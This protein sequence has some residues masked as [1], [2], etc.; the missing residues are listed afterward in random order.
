MLSR[1]LAL[2]LPLAAPAAARAQG[3]SGQPITLVVPYAAGGI[4]DI[5]ARLV[6]ERLS[7]RL[8]VP[9]VADNRSGAGGLI[10]AQ[11]VARAR[12]DG[13]TLLM[14]SSAILFV[15]AS[16][17]DLR[18]D[19]MRE[20]EPVAFVAGLPSVLTVN[21]SVP[22]RTM[23]EL[24]AWLRANPGRANCGNLGE[25][26]ND[27]QGCQAIERAAGSRMEHLTYRGLPP[28]DLDL[29]SGAIQMNIGS[30]PVQL[31]LVRE[32]KLRLLAVA[33]A[34]RLPELPEV[35][36]L[37]ESGVAYDALAGN[38]IFAPAGTPPAVVARLNA[39]IAALL[40]EPAV[41]ERIERLGAILGPPDTE[42]LRA[43]FQRDWDRA[44]AGRAG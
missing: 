38:A 42:S 11:A 33:T 21:P 1:R 43:R 19:P 18:F 7:A 40:A 24:L 41:R 34:E 29:V 13:H 6:A 8:G 31:P 5:L 35:P 17:P 28:L 39:G 15:A 16:T 23:P 9:V 44:R 3:F 27:H 2:A 26:G 10:A 22:A 20:L 12:P 14:H 32:G 36:T 25:G 30:A 4:T 37:L